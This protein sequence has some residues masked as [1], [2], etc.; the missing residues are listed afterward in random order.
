MASAAADMW[1]LGVVAFEILNNERAFPEGTTPEEIR[2]A[3]SG[4]APL[5][6]EDGAPRA[7]EKRE[8][9]RAMQRLVMPCLARDPAKRPKSAAVLQSWHNMFDDM[10]TR[11]TFEA[12]EP[13]RR[14]SQ[15]AD[16]AT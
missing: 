5:P 14:D 15:P 7:A 6:W 16:T 4:H 1:A 2:A 10:A 11:G 3:L 12:Q 13:Q 9:M 8:E